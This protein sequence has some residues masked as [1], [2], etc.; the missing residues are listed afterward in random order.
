MSGVEAAAD[1]FKAGFAK[2]Y[3]IHEDVS[4]MTTIDEQCG[5]VLTRVSMHKLHSLL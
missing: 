2:H 5:L 4:S 1:S 3:A